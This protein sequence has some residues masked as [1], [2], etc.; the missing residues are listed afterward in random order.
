MLPKV[1]KNSGALED[2]KIIAVMVCEDWDTTVRIFFDEPGFFLNVLRKVDFMD[3]NSILV[4][5][6]EGKIEIKQTRSQFCCRH[7]QLSTPQVEWC[8][9]SRWEFQRNREE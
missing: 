5:R 6:D 9:L 4:G 2:D 8:L 7:K 1:Q 3:P